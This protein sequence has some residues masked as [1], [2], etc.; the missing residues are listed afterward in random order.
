MSKYTYIWLLPVFILNI[1]SSQNEINECLENNYHYQ[2][3]KPINEL[4]ESESENYSM[5]VVKIR[6][7]NT[8]DFNC[9]ERP[10]YAYPFF[11]GNND[12]D[13]TC[14]RR[15]EKGERDILFVFLYEDEYK[16]VGINDSKIFKIEEARVYDEIVDH[17]LNDQYYSTILGTLGRKD[18]G[19]KVLSY[20]VVVY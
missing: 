4:I 7:S 19:Y 18:C 2:L 17:K 5:V 9:Y 8:V 20:E 14:Y 3:I 1:Y 6:D 16:G 15:L 10:G 11:I 12:F 13:L